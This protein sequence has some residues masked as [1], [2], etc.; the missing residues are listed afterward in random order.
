MAEFILQ[1]AAEVKIGSPAV[2]ERLVMEA[3][4][5]ERELIAAVDAA[6]RLLRNTISELRHHRADKGQRVLGRTD[7]S[8]PLLSEV[9]GQIELLYEED[10][11]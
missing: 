10:A 4:Q 7:V 9:I 8:Y 11:E 5:D 3:E 6:S 2:L 1:P